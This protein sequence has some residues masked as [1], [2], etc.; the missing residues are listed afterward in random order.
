MLGIRIEGI[1]VRVRLWG[2]YGTLCQMPNLMLTLF[3]PISS[4]EPE[5]LSTELTIVK[6]KCIVIIITKWEIFY[7]RIL[8]P[9]GHS[10]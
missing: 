1:R 3:I 7:K 10:T 4:S 8:V 2:A 5:L 9:R 6:G